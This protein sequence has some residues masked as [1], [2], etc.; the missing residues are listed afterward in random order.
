MNR[1]LLLLFLLLGLSGFTQKQG[2]SVGFTENKGQIIDQKGKP[3]KAVNYLLNTSGLNVQLR[4]N[5]FSYDV[6]ETK[7]HPLSDKEIARWATSHFT[8][9]DTL[10]TP[11]Y[12]LEYIYH[13]IDIDFENSNPNVKLVAEGKST[14]YD[15]YYNVLSKPEGVLDVH[16][17]QKVTYQNI[18]SNIDVVFFIPEE[19]SKPVEYNFIV[20]PSGNISDIRMKFNGAKTEL[21]DNKIRMDVRFGQM[22]ET[23]PVSWTEND[24]Q[25][26]TILFKKI[27]NNVYGF[28]SSENLVGKKVIIDPTPNRLWGTYYGG[29]GY[30]I[31]G[32]IETDINNNVYIG[33]STESTSNIASSGSYQPSY[34][35]AKSGFL[36]KFEPNGKRNWGS[37]YLFDSYQQ[38]N[39]IFK[40]KLDA[41]GNIYLFGYTFA[42][43]TSIPSPNC[44]QP[45]KNNYSDGYLIKLN[46]QGFKQWGTYY[47]GSQNEA[48]NTICFD[49]DNNVYI[50]GETN[51]HNTNVFTTPG[52][53]QLVNN[54]NSDFQ[55]AFLAKFDPNGNRIWGT[56]YGG[57]GSDG[58]NGL[59]LG[60]DGFL[61]GCGTQNSSTNIATSGSYQST[62]IAN[63]G[64]MIIKFDLNGQRIWGTYICNSSYLLFSALRGDCLYIAGRTTNHTE[65]ATTGTFNETFQPVPSGSQLNNDN[66]FVI[67]FNLQ[68]QQ[69]VWG[70]YFYEIIRGLAVNLNNEVYFSGDTIIDSGMTTPNAYMPTKTFF[71]KSYLEKLNSNGQ[72]VWGTYYG[73]NLAEQFGFI[74]TDNNNDIYLYGITNGSTSGIATPDAYQTSLASNPDTYL[75]KF[76]DCQSITSTKSNSPVC[77]GSDL[78]LTASGGTNY[79]WTG[80]NGFVSNLP[81]PTIS[82]A[83]A[84]HSGQ[85]SCAI[86]GNGECDNTI[87]VEVLVGDT[88]KPIPDNANLPTITGDCNTIISKPTATDNCAGI[89]NATTSDPLSYSLP[90]T[91]TIHWNYNDGNGNKETQT[92]NVII[93]PVNLPT[94]SSDQTFCIQQNATLNDIIVTGQNVK[95]YDSS[96]STT[97]LPFN[98]ALQNNATYYVSQTINGCESTK[99]PVTTQ[100]QNTPAPTGNDNQSFCVSQNAT[101]ADI[102]LNGN[103]IKWY[104]SVNSNAELQASTAIADNGTYYA[105]QTANSCESVNRFMIQTQLISTLNANDFEKNICDSKKDHK[106][107][108]KLTDFN[109]NLINTSGNSFTYY[110]SLNGA[111]NETDTE[112]LEPN[113]ILSSGLNT[114]YVR[115]TSDKGCFQIVKLALTLV[116]EPVIAIPDDVIMCENKPIIVNAGTGFDTYLW[117][118]NQTKQSITINQPGNY[119]VTVIKNH[120]STPCSTTKNFTVSLSNTA[121]ITS[122]ETEDWTDNQN[123]ITVNTT[124]L[125]NYEYSLDDINYQDSNIF[126]DLLSGNYTVYVRDK[127]NCGTASKS[128]VFLLFYPKFFTPNGDG[129]HD[130]WYIK[131]SQFE[132]PFN[133]QIY[134]RY[135]K[136]LI[137]MKNT[138]SWDGTHNG[139]LMPSDDYWFYITRKDGQIHRGHFTLKR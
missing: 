99:V 108:V 86:T 92:Q 126:T 127:N 117:S 88:I 25:E 40:F 113:Q 87:T 76:K 135:G 53:F 27:K 61:Y 64:G 52:A 105:T 19:K 32:Y 59:Y 8:V 9:K 73:G 55:D 60:N 98:T 29:E 47:G 37:Y 121:S 137:S 63:P 70:T 26:V 13:R 130:N 42:D 36:A 109:S 66:S 50:G 43:L 83:T 125:G 5:G 56:F 12:T 35:G 93:T 94:T 45:T 7:K 68:T 110:A 107:S 123:K 39:G 24:K 54:S 33:G 16:K 90:G 103:S 10:K 14:D 51:S 23:I 128:P 49:I 28:E 111:Q 75:V 81:N 112:K 131:F 65:I 31:P 138:E 67:K 71:F 104:D 97:L 4:K 124:G 129:F 78:N 118:T 80:P 101:L 72:R 89:I 77:I 30:E 106:E 95:W 20:K 48:I 84:L 58:F 91:Y 21:I 6:Y 102:A 79:S 17:Y 120:G 116:N 57:S 96:S 34:M 74:T 139:T 62:K 115:I 2:S 41:I 46:N 122:I 22:E 85:Y 134:D 38:F 114:I 44:F 69:K 100:V 119:S 82:N 136:L 3:N 11:N 133:V 132:D 15:N 1:V 18:Y